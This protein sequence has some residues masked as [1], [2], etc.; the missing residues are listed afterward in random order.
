[1]RAAYTCTLG[2]VAS[3][4]VGYSSAT[5]GSQLTVRLPSDTR[6]PLSGISAQSFSV[7]QYTLP[8]HGQGYTAIP[9]YRYTA[10]VTSDCAL[11]CQ[12]PDDN[13]VLNE[14][15]VAGDHLCLQDMLR[16]VYQTIQLC[17]IMDDTVPLS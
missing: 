10:L 4:P 7:I 3:D 11:K 8:C 2:E 15:K 14:S 6:R 17:K 12:N 16:M 5:S 9:P 1:M 13:E